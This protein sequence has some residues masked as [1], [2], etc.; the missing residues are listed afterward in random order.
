[1]GVSKTGLDCVL[2]EPGRCFLGVIKTGLEMVLEL[3]NA[4]Q[5]NGVMGSNLYP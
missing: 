3:I 2:E 4:W 5:R 1:L